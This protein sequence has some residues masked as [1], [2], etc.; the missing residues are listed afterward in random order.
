[1]KERKLILRLIMLCHLD[2]T[3]SKIKEI[4]KREIMNNRPE[5]ISCT[6]KYVDKSVIVITGVSSGVSI[7]LLATVI[8]SPI[9]LA[10]ASKELKACLCLAIIIVLLART[11]SNIINVLISKGLGDSDISHEEFLLINNEIKEYNEMK[12]KIGMMKSE[13]RDI[14]GNYL[15]TK[16]KYFF[17]VFSNYNNGSD[18]KRIIR[19]KW[20]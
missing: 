9:E 14:K 4:E 1:M 6:L 10:S 19:K 15:I 7:S 13:I 3:I 2:L 11:K 18:N 5:K 20:Y 12:K 8:G 16:E 17:Y